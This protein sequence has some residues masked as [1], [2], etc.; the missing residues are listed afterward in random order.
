MSINASVYVEDL[1]AAGL[2]ITNGEF[3]AWHNDEWLPDGQAYESNQIVVADGNTG[4]LKIV[5][6][7][8]WGP[9]H[10]I[11][12]V[13]G[14]GL[15]SFVSCEFVEWAEQDTGS[16]DDVNA[17]A[18]HL[19]S[20]SLVLDGNHFQQDKTQLQLGEDTYAIVTS[21]VFTG[22]KKWVDN[23]LKDL[24]EST[25][26][27]QSTSNPSMS[28]RLQSTRYMGSKKRSFLRHQQQ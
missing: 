8:F 3:T 2:L 4:P 25:N 5:N 12:D 19:R 6:S 26:I 28:K 21:N 14:T 16:E 15:V 7:A 17:P 9:T 24:Q 13:G 11:A 20:G 23:G 27:Y 1:Q 18:I 10:S 22:S